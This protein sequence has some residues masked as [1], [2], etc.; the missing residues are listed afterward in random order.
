MK[1]WDLKLLMADAVIRDFRVA[2]SG[3][4][5]VV[6]SVLVR[7]PDAVILDLKEKVKTCN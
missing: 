2:A 5:S 6:D 7:Y 1:I 4:Q 3:Y